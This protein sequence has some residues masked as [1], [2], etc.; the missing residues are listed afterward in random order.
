M[1]I[2]ALAELIDAVWNRYCPTCDLE[3]R[4]L[5]IDNGCKGAILDWLKDR[6]EEV[7]DDA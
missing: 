4:C 5:K 3:S 2:E 1:N 7:S 6:L